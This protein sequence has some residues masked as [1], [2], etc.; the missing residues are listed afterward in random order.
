MSGPP[1]A[2]AEGQAGAGQGSLLTFNIRG[3]LRTP[4]LTLIL[5]S[6]PISAPSYF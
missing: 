3:V 5:T 6:A 1:E 2:G 4:Q